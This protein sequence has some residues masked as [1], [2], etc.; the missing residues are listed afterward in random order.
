MASELRHPRTIPGELSPD[1]AGTGVL[2][3]PPS[4][5]TASSNSSP[6]TT[7]LASSCE[8]HSSTDKTGTSN[9][10]Q[11]LPPKRIG[12][13]K[14]KKRSALLI[15]A[16]FC[17]F[18][19]IIPAITQVVA[20]SENSSGYSEASGC[21]AGQSVPK[22]E[23]AF[24]ITIPILRNLS[25]AQAKLIDLAWDIVIGHGGRLLHG[26]VLY[27]ATCR[28]ITWI[29]ERSG[30]RYSFLLNT[31]FQW[32]SL[33]GLW[34]LTKSLFEKQ[35]PRVFVALALSTYAMTHVLLF[36]TI[37]GATTGY[38][39]PTVEGFGMW[40]SD[41][42]VKSSPTLRMCWLLDARG[43]GELGLVDRVILG[44]EFGSVFDS[45]RLTRGRE[46]YGMWE[47]F[48]YNDVP[49]DFRDIYNCKD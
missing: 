39:S 42:V 32:S 12:P 34:S 49:Q 16:M 25:F 40:D 14:M 7:A 21:N 22:M 38:Q 1:K 27:H 31:L 43:A 11:H 47:A 8:S 33:S 45:I 5:F 41:W 3:S 46:G 6:P 19:L 13:G 48:S 2:L 28:V 36:N 17:Y 9:T 44:P 29:L 24:Q 37:W 4:Q 30:L 23:S 10:R 15:L 35:R 26:W 18:I 20:V